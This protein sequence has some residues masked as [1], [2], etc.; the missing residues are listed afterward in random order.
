VTKRAKRTAVVDTSG[1]RKVFDLAREIENPVNFSIGQPDFDVPAPVVETLVEAVRVGRTRY[2]PTQGL[3]ELREA[4]RL[5]MKRTRDWEPEEVCITSG[6]SGGLMLAFLAMVDAGDDV[7]MAD[8]YFLSY[9]Q[10]AKLLDARPVVIDTYPDFRLTAERAEAALTPNARVLVL[11]SPANPTGAVIDATE[12]EGLA[13]ICRRRGIAVVSDEIYDSFCY[14]DDFVSITRHLPEA[15]VLGGF[16]KSYAMTGLRLGYACGPRD[17]LQEMMKLQQISFVCA[18]APV[19]AAGLTALETD[20]SEHIAAYRRKR[21]LVCEG[22]AGSYELVKPS[23][24][25]Y[26][27]PKVPRGT[28]AAFVARAIERGCLVIPGSVF[29]RRDTHFRLSYATTE[30][31]IARGVEILKSLA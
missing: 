8:P 11:N 10:L 1:I 23:G 17:V 31:E 29:S 3:E 25:F 28:D 6:V 13:E 7:L 19:Q 9:L 21:D 5:H 24:A 14:D 27:F 4:V 20:V 12:L 15:V 22:L 16:S 26:V 2:T 30:E 18:P